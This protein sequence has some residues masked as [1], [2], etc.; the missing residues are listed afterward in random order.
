MED[1]VS[2]VYPNRHAMVGEKGHGGI[3]AAVG[4][5]VRHHP[6]DNA[7]LVGGE[8]SGGYGFA[9][10]GIRGDQDRFP[11]FAYALQNDVKGFAFRRKPD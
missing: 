10:K 11:C 1:G 9:G 4:I 8:K 3:S 7:A 2:A 5:S 6:H